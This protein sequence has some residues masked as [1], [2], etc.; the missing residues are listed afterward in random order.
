M[1]CSTCEK[2]LAK[3]SPHVLQLPLGAGIHLSSLDAILRPLTRRSQILRLLRPGNSKN[4]A[5]TSHQCHLLMLIRSDVILCL[6]RPDRVFILKSFYLCRLAKPD[7]LLIL[8]LAE[9]DRLHIHREI[10]SSLINRP[11]FLL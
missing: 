5:T 2:D 1:V 4:Q 3:L 9:P 11:G 6:A 10:C 7:C 8:M